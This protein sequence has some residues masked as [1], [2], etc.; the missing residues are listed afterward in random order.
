MIFNMSGGG[1][2]TLAIDV[3]W[4]LSQPI[5]KENRTWIVTDTEVTKWEFAYKEPV[6]II[7][8]MVWFYMSI[9]SQATYAPLDVFTDA[10][11]SIPLY[12]MTAYQR[13]SGQWVEKEV[14]T[15]Q[16]GQ[17]VPWVQEQILIDLTNTHKQLGDNILGC[18]HGLLRFSS[19]AWIP[20]NNTNNTW[21]NIL[22]DQVVSLYPYI[23][24]SSS[25]DTTSSSVASAQ[26]SLN[27]DLQHS[28][29]DQPI[30]ISLDI[31]DIYNS[32]VGNFYIYTRTTA[33]YNTSNY[34]ATIHISTSGSLRVR[35]NHLYLDLV[36]RS[37]NTAGNN[38]YTVKRIYI[39]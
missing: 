8:G 29:R 24:I 38:S 30:T 6:T 15:Y 5:T 28:S 3:V 32:T 18:T 25:D 22:T 16:H 19:G 10:V 4:G 12:P 11:G 34:L 7:D 33:A 13:I 31:S 27:T 35:G 39:K 1:A 26:F 23:G 37:D 17:W 2:G 20:Y 14:K 9:L 21:E 36:P